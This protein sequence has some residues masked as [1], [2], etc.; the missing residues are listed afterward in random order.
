MPGEVDETTPW[1]ESDE[2]TLRPI[3]PVYSALGDL[4]RPIQRAMDRLIDAPEYV[5]VTTRA[6]IQL[7][8]RGRSHFAEVRIHDQA[9]V[10]A[11]ARRRTEPGPRPARAAIRS[12]DR[13]DAAA[14]AGDLPT[15]RHHATAPAPVSCTWTWTWSGKPAAFPVGPHDVGGRLG[16]GVGKPSASGDGEWELHRL[17]QSRIVE[18]GRFEYFDSSLF[19]VL[20]RI[21]RFEQIVPEVPEPETALEDP[22]LRR[23]HRKW[24]TRSRIPAVDGIIG[25][26]PKRRPCRQ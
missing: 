14:G 6:W 2:Q 21:E 24:S 8:Q 4:S 19:G 1:L 13:S 23:I 12:A 26:R 18:P 7:A 22:D 17:R 3:P 16:R 15:R 20:V 5:P 25:L 11:Q 9:V 10:D